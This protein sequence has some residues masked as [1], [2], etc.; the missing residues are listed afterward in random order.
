L[1]LLLYDVIGVI[2]ARKTEASNCTFDDRYFVSA[3][4]FVPKKVD[5]GLIF[6]MNIGCS[7]PPFRET[8]NITVPFYRKSFV[9]HDSPPYRVEVVAVFWTQ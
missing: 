8:V 1:I 2:L 6:Q 9:K 5:I 7:I 4:I 3:E